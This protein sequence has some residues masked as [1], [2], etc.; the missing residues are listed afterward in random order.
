M[1][2]EERK[3]LFEKKLKELLDFTEK[4]TR[5]YQGRGEEE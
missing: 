2:D 5:F 1:T 4:T 3:E